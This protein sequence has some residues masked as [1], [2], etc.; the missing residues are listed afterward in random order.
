[1]LKKEFEKVLLFS[2]EIGEFCKNA[3]V[4]E[5]VDT[6]DLQGHFY[7]DKSSA[8]K[9]TLRVERVKFGEAFCLVIPSQ[10]W[11]QEGVET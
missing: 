8:S 11:K 7:S 5:S 4:V 9:E 6:T 1:M 10:A 2:G 3:P